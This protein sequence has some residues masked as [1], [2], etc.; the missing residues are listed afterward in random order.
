MAAAAKLGLK[1]LEFGFTISLGEDDYQTHY[2]AGHR[3]KEVQLDS[4]YG[5]CFRYCL[6]LIPSLAMQAFNRRDLDIQL[7]LGIR[8][9]KLRRC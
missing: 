7:R 2:I 8:A 9:F 6:G 3:P 5:L 4:R 1:H